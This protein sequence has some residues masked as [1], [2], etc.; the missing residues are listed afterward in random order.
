MRPEVQAIL[1]KVGASPASS[2]KTSGA[3]ESLSE[4][5]EAA[6]LGLDTV[7]ENL[8]QVANNSMNE[9]MRLAATRD[10]LKMHGA[11]R[12]Q[13]SA[14]SQIPNFTIII[15]DKDG[16]VASSAALGGENPIFLPRQLLAQLDKT[17]S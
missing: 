14:A 10:A 8:A 1:R 17:A 5:L 3:D 7:L 9:G 16:A 13:P 15:N 4:R 12:E 2:A 11:L 6:G